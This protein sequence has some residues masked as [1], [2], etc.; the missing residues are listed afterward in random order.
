VTCGA[1][2]GQDREDTNGEFYH[3][4]SGH[5]RAVLQTNLRIYAAAKEPDR[6]RCLI[7]AMSAHGPKRTCWRARC[8][9]PEIKRRCRDGPTKSA[10]DPKRTFGTNCT[11]LMG[12]VTRAE[13]LRGKRSSYCQRS[14]GE[15][16]NRDCKQ[17]HDF[18]Q[19]PRLVAGHMRPRL[20]HESSMPQRST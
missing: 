1:R 19:S 4:L 15:D 17:E 8:L 5:S 3:R 18:E 20:L 10:S 11:S 12:A 16:A 9:L 6:Y 14:R 13:S 7:G 2:K